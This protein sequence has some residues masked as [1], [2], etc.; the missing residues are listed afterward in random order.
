M[1]QKRDYV[2]LHMDD[3]AGPGILTAAGPAADRPGIPLSPNPTAQPPTPNSL[4]RGCSL[5][6][7]LARFQ[8]FAV[9][10]ASRLGSSSH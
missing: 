4:L 3:S 9:M 6:I 1:A 10:A 8:D 2:N 5:F 7:L